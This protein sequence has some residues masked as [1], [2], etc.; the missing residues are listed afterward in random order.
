ME[1]RLHE[2]CSSGCK[3]QENMLPEGH[4]CA[5]VALDKQSNLNCDSKLFHSCKDITWCVNF[6]SKLCNYL[7]HVRI[8]NIFKYNR[9]IFIRNKTFYVPQTCVPLFPF[10]FLLFILMN[11]IPKKL[12]SPPKLSCHFH[13]SFLYN[14]LACIYISNI[15]Y[16]WDHTK[17][18]TH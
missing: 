6:C 10:S 17:Y 12:C 7:A 16:I 8:I 11:W 1:R 13:I 2:K 9:F 18:W 4:T 14:F 3:R 15:C 5:S